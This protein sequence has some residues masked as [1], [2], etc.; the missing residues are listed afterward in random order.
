MICLFG[1]IQSATNFYVSFGFK[2]SH[3]TLWPWFCQGVDFAITHL[4]KTD[5]WLCLSSSVFKCFILITMPMNRQ[6]LYWWS[7]IV[8]IMKLQEFQIFKFW[9]QINNM[10]KK[11]LGPDHTMALFKPSELKQWWS[12]LMCK[13]YSWQV[14]NIFGII[15]IL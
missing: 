3:L 7:R 12:I 1:L 4:N 10:C 6:Y 14:W 5:L 9:S 8:G 2:V 13:T 11:N 15:L